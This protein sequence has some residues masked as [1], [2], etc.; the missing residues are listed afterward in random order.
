MTTAT[1]ISNLAI[2]ILKETPISSI[3]DERPIAMWLKRNFAVTRDA[4]LTQTEWNFALKRAALPEDSEPPAFGWSKS[5]TL[6]ADC[7]RL[8]PVTL[9]GTAEGT[10]IPHEVEGD[11]VLTNLSGPLR[12]R[13]VRRTEEYGR[14]PATFIEALAAR[15][16]VKMAHWLTGKSS[17]VQIAEGLYRDAMDRAWLSDAV[18]GTS[19]RAADDEWVN[20][21]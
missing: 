16:A 14:Y 19:P 11:A 2:D 1:D 18:Q 8:L 17:Y 15:L 7:I 12:V 4:L 13:Y 9:C 20:R 3:D 10:P 6:P 5:Y 21:R